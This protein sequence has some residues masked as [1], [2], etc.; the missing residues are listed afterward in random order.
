MLDEWLE[1]SGE[2]VDRL[3]EVRV[4]GPKTI[5][6][7]TLVIVKA[8]VEGKR[9]IAFHSAA[10]SSEAVKGALEKVYNDSLVF[11]DDVPWEERQGGDGGA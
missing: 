3:I 8:L 6:G 2:M 1:M 7:D 10:S 9:K 11:K 4:K 5:G